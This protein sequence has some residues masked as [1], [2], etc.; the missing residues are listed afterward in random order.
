MPVFIVVN[1]VL[2]FRIVINKKIKKTYLASFLIN[3]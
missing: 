3:R 2:K 1:R